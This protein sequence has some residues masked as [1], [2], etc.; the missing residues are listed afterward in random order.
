MCVSGSVTAAATAQCRLWWCLRHKHTHTQEHYDSVWRRRR[1]RRRSSKTEYQTL[2]R[3]DRKPQTVMHKWIERQQQQHQQSQRAIAEMNE[4]EWER[5]WEREKDFNY[6]TLWAERT[7]THTHTQFRTKAN[8][9]EPSLVWLEKEDKVR[10][11]GKRSCSSHKWSELLYHQHQ[12]QW[13]AITNGRGKN[14]EK[15]KQ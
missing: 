11:G 5:E 10:Q 12:C 4:R 9:T 15:M 1:R 6:C 8:W 2:N 7:H 3:A 14:E 13:E